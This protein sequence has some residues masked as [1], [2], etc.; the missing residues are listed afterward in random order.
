MKKIKRALISVY[1]KKKLKNLLKILKKNR[2]QIFSSGGTYKEI[3][4][5]GFKTIEISD[6]TKSP[7]VL[8]GRVKTLNPKIHAGILMKRNN[9][10]HKKESIKNNFQEI[11]LVVVNFYP[12]K[13]ALERTNNHNEILE[14]IDIGGP[15]LVRAAAKNYRDVTI[16]CD[17]SQY[18]E[19]IL[20]LQKNNCSTSLKLREKL[21]SEAFN[22]TASYDSNIANYF[23]NITENS[24]PKKKTFAFKLHEK[25]RYG[26]N[27]HQEASV[28]IDGDYKLK[29]LNGKKLSYNNYSDIFAA[30][31][32]SK[33]LP[34]NK[35]TVIVKH[36]N[37]CGVSIETNKVDSFKLALKSDPISAFGGIVS[38][39][40]K[41]NKKVAEE[42]NKV[43]FEVIIADGFDKETLRIF[44]RKKNLRLIDSS[45]L[46][47]KNLQNFKND[48]N[49]LLLQSSDDIKFSI[50]NFKVVSKLK[51]TRKVLN[52]LIFAFN[53]CRFVKSNAIVLTHGGTTVGIGSGQPSRLD[54][55]KIAINK[56]KKFNSD[57]SGEILAA[58]DA[59]FPFVDGIETLVQSGVTAVIQPSGSVRD[60]EIIRYANETGTILV[61]SKSRHFNH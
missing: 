44:R 59:F 24:F 12:F 42:I 50:K 7:E 29:Q 58:S 14:N 31:R 60:K 45:N 10:K 11:D 6:Y 37:P 8:D 23:N 48:F 61:F 33:T 20:H 56:L 49:M 1:D 52:N 16:I 51:P 3:T 39:N 25:L 22:A 47:N 38:C 43:F 2:V 55:C 13:K 34:K 15:A 53:I 30:L 4:K 18:D 17:T 27:P 41:I 32:I 28:Y 26:E 36:A 40:F 35:G 21:S 46:K 9:A 57:I 5:L 54:S 19:L